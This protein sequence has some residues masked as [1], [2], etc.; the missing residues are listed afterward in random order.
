M[1]PIPKHLKKIATKIKEK[2]ES[3]TMHICCQC[4]CDD[5][6]FLKN[7]SKK[8]VL[9]NEQKKLIKASE[10]W[11]WTEYYPLIGAP[12]RAVFYEY[13]ELGYKEIF[14]YN[15]R[16]TEN[17]KFDKEIDKERI[18]RYFKLNYGEF[19][20]DQKEI[21]QINPIDYTTIIKVKCSKCGKEHLLFDNR[22]HGCDSADFDLNKRVNYEFIEKVFNKNIG[23]SYKVEI[24]IKNYWDFDDV[25]SNGNEG[26]TED[27]YS[28]LFGYISIKAINEDNKKIKVYSEELG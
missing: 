2:N 12:N 20:L 24:L 17:R 16:E 8:T 19:P 11:W 7:I 22:I 1:I 26:L 9:T 15:E 10:K 18:V 4:G 3:L 14:I 27:D 6:V 21:N 5:F 13:P 28:I 25:E 23:K